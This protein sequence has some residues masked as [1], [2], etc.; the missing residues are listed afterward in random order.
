M[1][2]RRSSSPRRAAP[3]TAS[4]AGSRPPRNILST[5]SHP[6]A[7]RSS[8]VSVTCT[9]TTSSTGSPTWL[10]ATLTST[11]PGRTRTARPGSWRSSAVTS[12][13]VAS[14]RS[15]GRGRRPAT[16]STSKTWPGPTSSPSKA[17]KRPLAPITS[18]PVSKRA[19]M[20][21]TR[22]CARPP[23]KTSRPCT[24]P[25]QR[26][27]VSWLQ[28][29]AVVVC[30]KEGVL[31]VELPRRRVR[32]VPAVADGAEEL[33][34][35]LG[36]RHLQ[37]GLYP[38]A[39]PD[40]VELAPGGNAVHVRPDLDLRQLIPLL[41]G[42]LQGV[43]DQA[44]DSEVPGAQIRCRGRSVG[45]DRPAVTDEILPRWHPLF[46]A[47]CIYLDAIH[48]GYSAEASTFLGFLPSCMGS[49]WTGTSSPSFLSRYW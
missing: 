22:S 45:Q 37:K 11:G 34:L 31:L 5:R 43:L 29:L 17:A 26:I 28:R 44:R 33:R 16:T 3:S 7:S 40:V 49:A 39:H 38:H 2:Q 30:R 20:S 19:S 27:A 8:P 14:Q 4:S 13:M 18:E 36:L 32:R 6:T 41:P 24:A 15:L 47:P 23:T 9:T 42:E 48:P 46:A 10:C 25:P 12:W 21:Y 35:R 1:I